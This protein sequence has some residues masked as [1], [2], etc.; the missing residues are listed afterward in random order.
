MWWLVPVEFF[1][2]FFSFFSINWKT[3]LLSENKHGGEEEGGR[4][5]YTSSCV[6]IIYKSLRGE[7]QDYP[8]L[9]YRKRGWLLTRKHPAVSNRVFFSPCG[10]RGGSKHLPL[11]P[12]ESTSQE[13][14][15]WWGRICGRFAQGR[16]P[17]TLIQSCLGYNFGPLTSNWDFGQII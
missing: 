1:F 3:R 8:S 12:D 4:V 5:T 16:S 10:S 14:A 11:I 2:C 9:F 13:V 7:K 17:Q 15:A 6:A